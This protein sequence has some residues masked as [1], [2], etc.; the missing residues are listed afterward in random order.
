MSDPIKKVELEDVLSSIRRLVALDMATVPE[1]PAGA[2]PPE[3]PASFGRSAMPGAAMPAEA[4]PEDGAER[5]E[6]PFAEVEIEEPAESPAPLVLTPSLRISGPAAAP[7]PAPEV[8]ADPS[9]EATAATLPP[10]TGALEIG[11]ADLGPA[12]LGPAAEVELAD[13]A[14]DGAGP[15]AFRPLDP[16]PVEAD[17]EAPSRAGERVVPAGA[18]AYGLRASLEETI[19]ELEAAIAGTG[20]EW[21]PDGSEMSQ[22]DLD[23]DDF[24]ADALADALAEEL[25]PGLAPDLATAAF[26]PV[27]GDEGAAPAPEAAAQDPAPATAGPP[28]S[29]GASAPPARWIRLVTPSGPRPGAEAAQA[30]AA[31]APS[32]EAPVAEA[33]AEVAAEEPRDTETSEQAL[34]GARLAAE[35][36]FW[37]DEA[38]DLAGWPEEGG[39]SAATPAG[40]G[41]APPEGPRRLH[42]SGAMEWDD[43]EAEAG[44]GHARGEDEGEAPRRS[45]P[46]R[47]AEDP[48]P[49]PPASPAAAES[50][51]DTGPLDP[52]ALRALVAEII[53]Q[54][55][56]GSLGERIT[57][58]VRKLVRR[59]IERALSGRAL[60]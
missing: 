50:D 8:P 13:I 45:F 27:S 30:P 18:E 15:A 32:A 54:E 5:D 42:F 7:D 57:R 58:N 4:E 56:Q 1:R 49:R 33:P 59:E 46:R 40:A 17:P 6:A 28:L 10:D 24:A 2:E 11:P 19:A 47:F 60:D 41:A 52:E 25:V 44:L 22:A 21:E 26:D 35:A 29:A 36:R 34:Q 55:L 16:T 31:E 48:A 23:F 53:R 14:R 3:T 37:H 43:L 20:G 9:P 39:R 12:D 51:L 38:E